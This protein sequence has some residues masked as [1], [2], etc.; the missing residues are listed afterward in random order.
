MMWGICR[1]NVLGTEIL[2]IE[3][4]HQPSPPETIEDEPPTGITGGMN[5]LT[6]RRPVEDVQDTNGWLPIGFQP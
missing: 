3:V 6:E 2:S 1:F 5:S 4:G